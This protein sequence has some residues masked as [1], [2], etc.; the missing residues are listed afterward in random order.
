MWGA[1][2]HAPVEYDVALPHHRYANMIPALSVFIFSITALFALFTLRSWEERRGAR[3]AAGAREV[4]DGYARRAKYAI[5]QGE[6]ALARLPSL[7]TFLTLKF[8][9]FLSVTLARMARSASEAA[10][11]LA[12]FIS[13]KHNFERRELKSEFLKT[14]I[15]HKNGLAQPIV[16]VVKKRRTRKSAPK[17]PAAVSPDVPE[18]VHP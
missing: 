18:D 3:I 4:L 2:N 10:H 16:E 7:G 8:L 15:E 9:S 6:D 14:M 11:R 13:H 17:A 12:D 1:R 5:E